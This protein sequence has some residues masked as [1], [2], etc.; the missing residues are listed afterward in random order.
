MDMFTIKAQTISG[1]IALG[2]VL[3]FVPVR[4]VEQ[5]KALPPEARAAE[6]ASLRSAVQAACAELNVAV[7]EIKRTLGEDKAA[8]FACHLDI[9]MDD[10]FQK[11]M[12]D[13]IAQEGYAAPY[14]AKVVS[15]KNALEMEELEDP[16]FAA[17]A[18][19]F[20]DIGQRLISCLSDAGGADTPIRGWHR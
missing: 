13:L 7:E 15:E 5:K 4:Q 12:F 17:R 19:D 11:D 2:K 1:G 10:E 3:N 9:L 8:I 16:L 18:A 14:A 20:R 6:A